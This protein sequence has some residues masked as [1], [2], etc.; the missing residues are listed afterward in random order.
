MENLKFSAHRSKAIEK[1]QEKKMSMSL[2]ISIIE[3]KILPIFRF[4]LSF[5]LYRKRAS[6]R[7][8]YQTMWIW[9]IT[10]INFVCSSRPLTLSIMIFFSNSRLYCVPIKRHTQ[11]K[12]M[13]YFSVSLNI[14]LLPR[15]SHKNVAATK[16]SLRVQSIK[17]CVGFVI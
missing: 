14:C 4:S 5:F 6:K 15:A 1:N 17:P 3:A 10:K 13:K 9:S 8:I 12:I 16:N 7:A 2:S 11:R